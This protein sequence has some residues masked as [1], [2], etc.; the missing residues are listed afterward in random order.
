MRLHRF[1][2]CLGIVMST[3]FLQALQPWGSV[4][5]QADVPGDVARGQTI[6]EGKGRCLTCHYVANHGSLLGP[7]LSDIGTRM[8]SAEI[9]SALVAPEAEVQAQNRLYSVVTREG[10]TFTGKLLNQDRFSLQMLDSERQLMAFEKSDLRQYGF[11][12]T[13]PMPSYRDKLNQQELA[14]LVAFLVSL[15]GVHKE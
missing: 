3:V 8:T 5:Q 14:D 11:A 1:G 4:A 2:F 10:A 7:D 9:E 12:K 15:K 6:F 13:P